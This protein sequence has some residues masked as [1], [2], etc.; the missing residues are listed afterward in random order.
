[1]SEIALN[2]TTT[3]QNRLTQWLFNPFMFVAGLP[4]LSAGLAII[5]ISGFFCW[6]GN[7]HF[8]GVI[9]CHIGLATQWWIF[10]AEGLINWILLA[11]PLFFFGLIISKSS[12]RLID[13]FG[14]QALARGPYLITAVVMLP[15]ANLKVGNFIFAKLTQTTPVVAVNLA[16]I[17][18]FAVAMLLGILM[19]V[20]M[21]V[22]MYR[23]YSISC[24]VK[25]PKAIVTF[26]I[27][28][29]GT[30]IISKFAVVWLLSNMR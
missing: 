5:L 18:I 22:L 19:A 3:F 24:N 9:D 1:M 4:A 29:I 17:F 8:D 12:F 15:S 13:V 23:A 28:L 20:W 30:E 11:I 21:V 14:T 26:I 25:G 27:A 7:T 16:D 6:L 2:S 10:P